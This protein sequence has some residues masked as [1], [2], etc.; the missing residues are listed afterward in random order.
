MSTEATVDSIYDYT[1]LDP[2]ILRNP[3]VAH[4]T[5]NGNQ[6]LGSQSV[7]GLEVDARETEEGIDA[8]LVLRQDTIIEH[9]VHLC[10]AMLP[11]EG[12]QRINLNVTIESGARVSFLAHCIFPN[13]VKVQHIMDAEITVGE[14]AS[15]SYVEEHV[16]SAAGGV[17]VYPRA[18]VTV[19]RGASFTTEFDLVRGRVGLIDIDYETIAEADSVVEM[20]ARIS[21]KEDDY[22]K[23]NETGELVGERAKG[24]LTTKIAARD[25]CHAEVHNRLTATAPHARGHVD[26]KEI[27]QDQAVAI[28]VP[29]VEVRHPKAHVTHEAAIGSVDHKQ[30]ETLLSRGLPED[31][32]VDLIISGMLRS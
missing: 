7:E 28:A 8:T 24:A 6:V 16:H 12:I 23:I 5:V 3:E 22:I 1:E 4:L 18:H 20:I 15:Y 25:K 19:G 10:F 29:I 14:N 11:E 17:E 21:G 31:D 32:A 9:P 13:A 26:C 27:V 2:R 30:L